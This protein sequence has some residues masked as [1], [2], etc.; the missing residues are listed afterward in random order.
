MP[1]RKTNQ[2]ALSLARDFELILISVLLGFLFGVFWDSIKEFSHIKTASILLASIGS[3][4]LVLIGLQLRIEQLISG[5][6]KRFDNNPIENG[7]KKH[8][9][10]YDRNHK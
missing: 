5:K 9:S 6:F 4:M 3:L 8:P 7:Q 1:S 2:E 10:D